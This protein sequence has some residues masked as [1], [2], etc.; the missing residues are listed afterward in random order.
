MKALIITCLV[1]QSL[2]LGQENFL[3]ISKEDFVKGKIFNSALSV[4]CVVAKVANCYYDSTLV[5]L[6][7]MLNQALIGVN[8]AV[9]KQPTG[10]VIDTTL[11]E[12]DAVDIFYQEFIKAAETTDIQPAQLARETIVYVLQS[13]NDSHTY[14]MNNTESSTDSSYIY[15]K[16]IKDSLQE[17]LYCRIESFSNGL[18]VQSQIISS[19]K[20]L[21]KV[22]AVIF[23]CRGNRGGYLDL[24][25]EISQYFLAQNTVLWTVWCNGQVEKIVDQDLYQFDMPVIF[26]V[27]K[28][29]YSA[30]EVLTAV[31]RR[32]YPKTTVIGEKTAGAVNIGTKYHIIQNYI[33]V[34]TSQ[35]RVGGALLEG[36]G[37]EP[38]VK[39]AST[40]NLD[41]PLVKAKQVLRKMLQQEHLSKI[42]VK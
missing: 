15:S 4:Y 31:F 17:Y 25:K 8:R 3:L 14:L 18:A 21:P 7:L 22:D 42:P 2:V 1:L 20:L 19:F 6:N 36:A 27:D 12:P 30:A 41:L 29:T 9:G 23:D 38:D 32:F 37:I 26:L 13:L 34:T 39:V 11:T 24:V 5:N 10:T 33:M 16:V 28:H 40:V 35:L